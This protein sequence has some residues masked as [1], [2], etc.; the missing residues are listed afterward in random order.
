VYVTPHRILVVDDEPTIRH[1]LEQMLQRKGC[2]VRQAGSAEEALPLLDGW[3]PDVAMFDV[4]MPGMNGLELLNAFKERC[5]ESEVVIMTGNVSTESV[6]R[7]IRGGAHDFLQK[8]FGLPEVWASL[9]KALAKRSV[10][11][12][13]RKLLRRSRTSRI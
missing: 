2:E 13:Q 5:P 10:A 7:A 6:Q 9:E 1:V 12:A 11:L 4:A 8:P 3:E